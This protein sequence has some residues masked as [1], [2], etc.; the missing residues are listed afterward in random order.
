[1]KCSVYRNLHK[2]CFSVKDG[3]KPYHVIGRYETIVMLDVTFVVQPAGQKKAAAGPKNVHAFAKGDVASCSN[4]IVG[5]EGLIGV[6]Y[7]PKKQDH[8]TRLDTGERI[9]SAEWVILTGN[10]IYINK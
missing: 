5:T 8:F 2:G 10:K 7:N 4:I 9:D 6:Y 3:K 1:M